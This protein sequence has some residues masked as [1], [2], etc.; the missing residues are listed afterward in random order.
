MPLRTPCFATERGVL[1][2]SGSARLEPCAIGLQMGGD[3]AEMAGARQL[4]IPISVR[5][6]QGKGLRPKMSEPLWQP[7]DDFS[8]RILGAGFLLGGA[9]VCAWQVLGTIREASAGASV[10]TYSITLIV[11]SV[12]F[13]A[14]G[15]LWLVRGLA[16]YTWVRS[17]QTEPRARRI[18]SVSAFVLAGGTWLLMEW[19][20][21]RK[22]Y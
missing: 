20:L 11:M 16:G 22:G 19:Y 21:G 14:L 15:A 6:L 5:T 18:L 17:V 12:M 3:A 9:G 2:P 10:L 8:A 7:R 4:S 1:K 13:V